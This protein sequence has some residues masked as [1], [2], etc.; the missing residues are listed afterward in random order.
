MIL[1]TLG[2][3]DKPFTRL[4]EALHQQCEQGLITDEIWVQSGFTHFSSPHFKL[5][6]YFSQHELD[7]AR[8]NADILITHGGVGSILDGL[9]LK[10]RIIGVARLKTYR[11]HI[12]DHQEEILK[13]FEKDGYLL[14]CQD[15]S[16]LHQYIQ[17]IKD[18]TP[19]AY[20][21]DNQALIKAI[22]GLIQ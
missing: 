20:P 5:Q 9:K 1:V 17:D 16:T 22:T 7:Q 11:E 8:A 4:L 3:Q 12:N 13:Q 14:W 2:T 10:K 18:F 19:Q 6:A 21:F 15:F